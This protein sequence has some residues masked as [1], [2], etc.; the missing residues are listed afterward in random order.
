MNAST[1]DVALRATGI[2][3]SA[4]AACAG[5]SPYRTPLEEYYRFVEAIEQEQPRELNIDPEK[6]FFGHAMEPVIRA[7]FARETGMKVR[8]NTRTFRS[9][10]HPHLIA[11]PDS[12]IVRERAILE[13]KTAGLRTI[14][15]WGEEGT[16]QVPMHY[17]VQVA[18]QMAVLDYDRA[19]LAVLLGANDLRIYRIDRDPELEQLLLGRLAEFWRRVQ[20][21]D[22]PPPSTLADAALRWSKD[23]G[24]AIAATPALVE[25]VGELKRLKRESKDLDALIDARE[26]E[27]KAYLGEFS[28]LT[29]PDGK[30]LC[31]WKAQQSKR[32]DQ[33]RLK[34]EAPEIY[35]R[36]LCVSE[37]RVLRIK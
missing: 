6:A 13:L 17:L 3:S 16:D 12:F 20:E 29:G 21:R 23:N 36:F 26:L 34:T 24:A 19:Q 2:G 14:R 5:V 18:H 25:C 15:A 9:K 8:A 31:T 30:A 33:T 10:Q 4:S 35:E 7:A 1:Y 11:T 22:P 27:L 32:L 28:E 37:S